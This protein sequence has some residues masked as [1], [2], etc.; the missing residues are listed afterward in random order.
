MTYTCLHIPEAGLR[1]AS[2]NT[3][4]LLVSTASAQ[5]SI[6]R[7]HRCLKCLREA[8]DIVCLQKKKTNEQSE[9]L[10]STLVSRWSEHWSKIRS[11][12][13]GPRCWFVSPC[14]NAKMFVGC[15]HPLR[16]SCHTLGVGVWTYSSSV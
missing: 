10:L 3:R 6:E 5:N 14:C 1:I 8:N 11:M 16:E 9:F 15:V 13:E 4:E 2:R 7:K 12:Q